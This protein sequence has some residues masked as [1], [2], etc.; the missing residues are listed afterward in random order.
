MEIRKVREKYFLRLNKLDEE[1]CI[2]DCGMNTK[3]TKQITRQ[4][5][6]KKDKV[7]L[8]IS[9]ANRLQ[10]KLEDNNRLQSAIEFTLQLSCSNIV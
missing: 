9:K 7:Q 3:D 2:D 1:V 6:S 5:E 4:V 8:F 10:Q